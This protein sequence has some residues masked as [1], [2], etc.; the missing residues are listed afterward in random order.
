M[1]PDEFRAW[2]R[3]AVDMV[4]D[5]MERV[6][7]LPVSA[8]GEFGDTL[9]ALPGE[10]PETGEAWGEIL[11]DVERVVMPGLTHWQ[12]PSFFGFF[13][14]NAPAPSV[15]ADILST[16]LG[17]QGMLWSTS[18]ACTE[19]ELRVMDWLG[20]L[21]GLPERFLF[22]VGAGEGGGVIQGTASE[23]ALVC[24]VAAIRRARLRA[25]SPAPLERIT[26]Y[27]STQ[28]HSSIAKDARVAGLPPENVRLIETDARHAMRPGA[29]RAAMEADARA[30]Y[31]PAFVCV[32]LGTTGCGAIDPLAEV[33]PVARGVGAWVHVDAAYAGAALVCPE[34][35]A[36]LGG[37][38]MADSFNFNPHK[39][40]LT[41]F[42]MSCLW[43]ADRRSVIDA[44]SITPEYL[45]NAA[46]E[47]G[48]VVDYRDWQVPLG[49][50]F[51][52]LK[53]WM[54][55]RHYGA[56]GLRAHVREGIG[57]AEKLAS[58]AGQDERF[59]VASERSLSLVCL[60]L[61][62]GDG[63]TRALLERV[64]ATRRALLTHTTLPD[65]S[66]G[67]R[68]VI[69]VAIGGQWTREAHVRALWDLLREE[70]GAALREGRDG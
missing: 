25:P 22:G 11:G 66:G 15:I 69:R 51:R 70:A 7:G 55:L 47:S 35:R 33:A 39:W 58:W 5:Y 42:D 30:G 60:R 38:E 28:A 8:G 64:N 21:I 14:C 10:A 1:T 68:T 4:A 48:R 24:L 45:R 40:L 18:P 26:V 17:V 46:S 13:P 37:V 41:A 59:E 6:G 20:R 16:G 63:A 50:R 67:Q 57:L 2:G 12:H 29:L 56:E 49:R 52:A 62:A 61:R 9:R 43:L 19:I 54:T 23:A 53:L 32:T 44:M 34:H 36:M 3:R 31:A 65:G 27:A